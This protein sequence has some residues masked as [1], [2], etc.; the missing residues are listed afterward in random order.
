M[1]SLID[2]FKVQF[3]GVRGS[4]ACPGQDT[5]RYGG[6]T[7]CVEMRVG[8][9]RLIF[10][11]GTGIRLL[12]DQIIAENKVSGGLAGHIFF[13]HSHWDHIQGFPFFSPAFV[14]GNRFDIYGGLTPNGITI[15]ERLDTQMM[16]P[17]FPV[18]L[19]IMG[20]EMNFHNLAV[21]EVIQLAAVT[22]ISAPL[23][24]PG[25]A[26]GYRVNYGGRSAAYVTDTEHLP[27]QLD[28]NVLKLIQGV[29]LFI[30]DCTYTDDEYGHPTNGKVG[31]GHSTWQEGV[32]LAKI[33]GVK[34]LAI[35]HHD[36]SHSDAFMDEIGRSAKALFPGAVVAQEGQ[37]Y[38]LAAN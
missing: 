20:A 32:R 29:D 30:Y 33:A 4:I 31:W 26:T 24:H 19:K 15:K 25:S 3:W 18:P 17:N 2:Q 38:D 11:A 16:D 34:Q 12:G 37:V 28:E 14:A 35:F 5:V 10:D 27:G 6:N 1:Y 36:P 13:S 21:G 7:A 23:N 8:G 9:Q 22:V